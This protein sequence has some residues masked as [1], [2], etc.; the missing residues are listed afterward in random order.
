MRKIKRRVRPGIRGENQA[1][2]KLSNWTMHF[3]AA[4]SASSHSGRAL[5]IRPRTR[6]SAPKTSRQLRSG[7]VSQSCGLSET[8]RRDYLYTSRKFRNKINK[9]HSRS[10]KQAHMRTSG[11]SCRAV[12]S[13]RL[14]ILNSVRP[15][16]LDM[17][18]ATGA[19]PPP[20][21]CCVNGLWMVGM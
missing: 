12:E 6:I 18:G 7:A 10:T 5:S 14:T 16:L 19:E 20:P 4:D 9:S 15:H 8:L 13:M 21:I 17:H 11:L 2:S 1:L 3:I